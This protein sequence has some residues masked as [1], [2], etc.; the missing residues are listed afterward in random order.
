MVAY[1]ERRT[2]YADADADGRLS[3]GEALC[4]IEQLQRAL[5]GEQLRHDETRQRLAA[6]EAELRSTQDLLAN[7][8]LRPVQKIV[9]YNALTAAGAAPGRAAADRG[10]EFTEVR[11]DL[12]ALR[13]CVSVDQVSAHL[14]AV[15][16]AGLLRKDVRREILRPEDAPRPRPGAPARPRPPV[17]THMLLAPPD[18]AAWVGTWADPRQIGPLPEVGRLR[19]DKTRQGQ[20]RA[21][22]KA[23]LASCGH[24]GCTDVDALEL[25]CRRCGAKT[26]VADLPDAG[27]VP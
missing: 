7:P 10:S 13:S 3:L 27:G 1:T 8:R 22:I 12:I 19:K 20:Q 17:L 5:L 6:A 9:A 24:C 2:G 25:V 14:D 21:A 23:I 15:V 26:V 18:G 16:A 4:R 11:R